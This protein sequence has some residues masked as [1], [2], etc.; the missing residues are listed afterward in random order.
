MLKHYVSNVSD[1]K[2]KEVLHFMC[3]IALDKVVPL[4][5]CKAQSTVDKVGFGLPDKLLTEQSIVLK[6][7]F[8]FSEIS[9]KR[10][11]YLLKHLQV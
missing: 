2:T 6:L 10:K 11:P 7:S 9:S 8:N 5:E 1:L 3:T 4:W